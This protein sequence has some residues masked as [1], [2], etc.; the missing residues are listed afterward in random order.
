MRG[1]WP[2]PCDAIAVAPHSFTVWLVPCCHLCPLVS[3]L[4][5]I[6]LAA[7]AAHVARPVRFESFIVWCSLGFRFVSSLLCF[8]FFSLSQTLRELLCFHRAVSGQIDKLEVISVVIWPR[9]SF[10]AV[11][12]PEIVEGGKKRYSVTRSKEQSLV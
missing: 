7:A 11:K 6:L 8:F 10:I 5:A 4:P 2:P 12:L 3:R 1:C 9:R